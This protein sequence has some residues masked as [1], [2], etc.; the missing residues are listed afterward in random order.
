MDEFKVEIIQLAPMRVICAKGFGESPEMQSQEKLLTWAKS[1]GLLE[2]VPLP[3]F[4][5]FNNPDPHPGSPNYGYEFWM[6]VPESV[7]PEGDLEIKKFEGGL[8]AV[9]EVKNVWEI[10]ET[11]QAFMRWQ[12]GSRYALAP[13]QYLEEHVKFIGLPVEEYVMRLYLP[14]AER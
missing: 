9:A 8:Y 5:G 14:V 1:K 4:F 10:P 7:Q 2:S 12:E 13:H 3:R 6:S 11:W